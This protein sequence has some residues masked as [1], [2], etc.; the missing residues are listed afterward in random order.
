MRPASTQSALR[1]LQQRVESVQPSGFAAR[2]RFLQD[3]LLQLGIPD[4]GRD[5]REQH[6]FVAGIEQLNA[7]VREA[8]EGS[9]S[10]AVLRQGL[11][12]LAPGLDGLRIPLHPA[13]QCRQLAVEQCGYFS[14][15]TRPL[16]LVFR[17]DLTDYSVIF[18]A[19]DDL[20]QDAIVLQLV[21]IMDD[22]WHRS[23]LDLRL[24]LFRCLPLGTRKGFIELVPACRTL[25]EVQLA[26]GAAGVFK[27]DVIDTFLRTNNPSEFRY[28]SALENFRRS[29]AGWCV[30]TYLLGV[31]DRHNDNILITTTGHVF[32]IDFG[33][34]LGD[35][36]M[37]AGIKRDRVPFILTP[38]MVYV[39]NQ[40]KQVSTEHF[41]EF[42]DECCQAFNLVR[43]HSTF[44]LNT[45]RFVSAP[46]QTAP[47]QMCCSDIPGL[48][49]AAQQFLE[50][51]LFLHLNDVDATITFTRMIQ[52][53]LASVFPR[54]NFFAHT[55]AQLRQ[56]PSIALAFGGSTDINHLSFITDTYSQAADGRIVNLVVSLYEKWRTPEKVYVSP[57]PVGGH[58]PACRCTSA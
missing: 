57:R 32:H 36:Q 35:W 5:V 25:R 19:G 22:I 51:N 39:I 10:T 18:K 48:G 37:A 20:R 47:A 53:S 11:R 56:N 30:A 23:G 17:G 31:G 24:I 27:D 43:R 38:E 7:L 50:S 8:P 9:S 15:L 45:V 14:S 42:I 26:S 58:R 4:L 1:Q 55:L 40:G 6:A 12:E 21:G 28:R 29:C 13:F 44:L 34:Y 16:R 3:T 46:G 33:K 49:V 41:Q 2:C 52:D 54:L